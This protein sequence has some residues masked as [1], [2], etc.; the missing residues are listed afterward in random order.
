MDLPKPPPNKKSSKLYLSLILST[1][2]I[3]PILKVTFLIE[4]P[5]K[6]RN[7]QSSKKA[8]KI[9][10][11]WQSQVKTKKDIA[12]ELKNDYTLFLH[13]AIKE[14]KPLINES[15]LNEMKKEKGM[16]DFKVFFDETLGAFKS[17]QSLL[18]ADKKRGKKYSDSN[19]SVYSLILRL[20]TLFLIQCFAKETEF[21]NKKFFEFLKKHGFKDKTVDSFLEVYR[22]EKDNKK[23]TAKISIGDIEKLFEA[24]KEEFA[25]AERL[26]E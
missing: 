19:A 18:E 2:P 10:R 14:A 20:R 4:L 5:P 25:K 3:L 13:Q 12:K 7:L 9:S 21:S 26:A 15:L 17:T 6:E 22:A 24:A 23:T 11:N 16:P 8:S 1:I